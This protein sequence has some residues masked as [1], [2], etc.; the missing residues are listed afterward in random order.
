MTYTYTA[1]RDGFVCVHLNLPKR[2]DF[3]VSVN[4]VE[5]YK[6]TISLSQMIA[7]GDV[8]TGDT[9]DIRIECDKDE[10]ST[11]T[12]SA[13]VLNGER[14][15]RGYEI[16]S[17]SQLN[18]TKFRSTL[19][20]GT[21]DC[22]RDGLLYTSVPQNGNWSVKVDGKPAEIK[23]VGDCMVAVNLTKGVHT[24]RLMYH[25]AAFSLGWKISLACAAVFGGL[26]WSIY[27]PDKKYK[28]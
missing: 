6:E 3:Y 16:L 28:K 18:L 7:V 8:K 1:D 21:I 23:L 11:M 15:A 24:V 22:D 2:N 26:A 5:L 14:F 4:G 10:S 20:E 19:V 12:V 25:N 27:R 9:V 13:A 17:A